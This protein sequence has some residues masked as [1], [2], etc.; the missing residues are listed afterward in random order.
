M[1]GAEGR[2]GSARDKHR[3]E[4]EGTTTTGRHNTTAQRCADESAAVCAVRAA[5]HVVQICPVQRC[6]ALLRSCA[7]IAQGQ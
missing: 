3:Q 6:V 7:A 4:S 2:G 5:A 1:G